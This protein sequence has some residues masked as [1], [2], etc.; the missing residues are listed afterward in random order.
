MIHLYIFELRSDAERSPI[1]GRY[2]FFRANN[3]NVFLLHYLFR[4]KRAA[5]RRS[6]KGVMVMS[7]MSGEGLYE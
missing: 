5:Y 7:K 2:I 3:R 6:K 1:G 4:K